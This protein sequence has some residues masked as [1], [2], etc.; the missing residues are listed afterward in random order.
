MRIW[1][2]LLIAG[3]VAGELLIG[4]AAHANWGDHRPWDGGWHA[5]WRH[6]PN[7]DHGGAIAG[8]VL[9]LGAAATLGGLLAS[10]VRYYNPPPVYAPPYYSGYYPTY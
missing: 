10:Q 8:A 3:T 1:S 7:H 9:G 4:P 6:T 2:G 5:E